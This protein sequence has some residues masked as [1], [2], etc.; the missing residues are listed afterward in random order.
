MFDRTIFG[1]QFSFTRGAGKLAKQ[2]RIGWTFLATLR[3]VAERLRHA[4][5]AGRYRP[6]QHYMRGPGPKTREKIGR[7]GG[8]RA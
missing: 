7:G 2:N 8:A 1:T 3:G 6:E 4:F 5:G